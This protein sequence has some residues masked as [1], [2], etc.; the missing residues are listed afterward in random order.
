MNWRAYLALAEVLSNTNEPAYIR[1]AISR[2]YYGIFNI[3]RIKAGYNV[4][5]EAES[6][7]K[8]INS[9]KKADGEIVIKL[10]IEDSDV[11]FLGN[12]LDGLRKE[13]NDADYD[14]L[15]N[16]TQKRAKEINEQVKEMLEMLFP[17]K[18]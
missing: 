5:G 17:A 16:F 15:A 7:I 6:H 18:K 3:A 12:Q 13:R 9:L 1:S 11:S 14:G 8:F 10:D 4:K 2:A